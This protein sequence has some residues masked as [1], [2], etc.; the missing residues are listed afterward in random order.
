MLDRWC[1]DLEAEVDA[2]LAGLEVPERPLLVRAEAISEMHDA[3]RSAIY[4]SFQEFFYRVAE[5]LAS[6]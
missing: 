1:R 5:L 3:V 6:P 4:N 2:A